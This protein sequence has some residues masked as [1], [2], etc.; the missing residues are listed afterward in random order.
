MTPDDGTLQQAFA[1]PLRREVL[2]LYLQRDLV[3]ATTEELAE[4]IEKPM[5]LVKYHLSVLA[6]S[7][8]ISTGG[9]E[10]SWQLNVEAQWLQQK[11]IDHGYIE[12]S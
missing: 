7:E 12:D 1:H 5:E 10:P 3:E 6:K 11:L 9:G 8:L 2:R 4:L